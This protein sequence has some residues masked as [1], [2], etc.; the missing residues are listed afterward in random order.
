MAIP[1]FLLSRIL[2]GMLSEYL[3]V[4]LVYCVTLQANIGIHS[5]RN[6][7]F[8][9]SVVELMAGGA[10]VVAHNS[11]GPQMDIISDGETGFLATTA[12]DYAEKMADI[13]QLDD[14]GL[15]AI[16]TRARLD[17]KRFSDQSFKDNVSRLL[18][19]LLVT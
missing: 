8:G 9:I 5:M 18:K 19:E 3:I 17:V 1:Y 15:Q 14:S 2:S 4:F 7:H 10:I 11:G 13:M 6:E 16:R 12:D